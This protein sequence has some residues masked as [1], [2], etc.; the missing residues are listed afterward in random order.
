MTAT[1]AMWAWALDAVTQMGSFVFV[2]LVPLLCVAWGI[3][4]M[5]TAAT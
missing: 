4:Y 1:P 2:A 5:R 3:R